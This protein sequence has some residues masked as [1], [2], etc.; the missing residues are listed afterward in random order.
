[1][2]AV[3][4]LG[5]AGCLGEPAEATAAA[6]TPEVTKVNEVRALIMGESIGEAP[7]AST[8][9]E[10]CRACCATSYAAACLR[11]TTLCAGAEVVTIGG[12]TIASATAV[13]AVCVSAAALGSVCNGQC[14]P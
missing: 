12:A 13:T 8:K 7:E 10:A 14:P 3:G 4:S 11:V 9:G 1:M 2:V 6:P 5:V